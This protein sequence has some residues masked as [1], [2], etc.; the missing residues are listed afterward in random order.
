LPYTP[1]KGYMGK[2]ATHFADA[3]VKSKPI[4]AAKKSPWVGIR[5][6]C[7]DAEID[8]LTYIAFQFDM[9]T[10]TARPPEP[11]QLLSDKRADLW[12]DGAPAR[13]ERLAVAW[14]VQTELANTEIS[15]G[16]LYWTNLSKWDVYANV[17]LGHALA[18]TP[19]YRYCL[20]VS[21]A[22]DG[23]IRFRPIARHY[24]DD[25][26]RQFRPYADL[27]VKTWGSFLPTGF[28]Q[29]AREAYFDLVALTPE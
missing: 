24:R 9:Q 25:A 21:I 13:A 10:N 12:R 26:M 20:A 17:I 18:L 28:E 16:L 3:P 22:K 23:G 5:D 19:L 29:D 8:P 6:W 2:P 7:K 1:P 4:T 15:V 14:R 11:L 27:Y